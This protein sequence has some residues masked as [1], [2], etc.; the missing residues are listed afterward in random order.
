MKNNTMKLA[1]VVSNYYEDISNNLLEGARSKYVE[2]L[3]DTFEK[4]VDIYKVPG[5]FEIC[6]T[7][8]QILTFNSRYDA[9]I[10][11]GC[12]IKGE[13]AHFDYICSSVSNGIKDLSIHE[14]TKIPILFGVLTTLNYKQAI[15]RSNIDDMDKG[16][17]V[18]TST[19]ETTNIYKKINN[20]K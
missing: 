10:T 12:I 13:T 14:K 11:F 9:I 19:I 8:R 3:G 5:A 15:A 7:V 4:N 20:N 2:I 1:I 6:G 17:D 18:M 16:G